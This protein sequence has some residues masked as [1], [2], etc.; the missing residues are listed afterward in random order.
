[1][2]GSDIHDARETERSPS[3]G[4][5]EVPDLVIDNLVVVELPEGV[6]SGYFSSSE[7]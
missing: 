5:G 3:N 2:R 6:G 1:M 4:E 7:A